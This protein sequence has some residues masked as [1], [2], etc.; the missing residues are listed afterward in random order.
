MLERQ[1]QHDNGEAEA[2]IHAWFSKSKSLN[3][4]L[5]HLFIPMYV[6]YSPFCRTFVLC[7]QE[8]S[9]QL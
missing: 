5:L 8:Y 2:K 7:Q 1:D 4:T 9:G 6:T 3:C